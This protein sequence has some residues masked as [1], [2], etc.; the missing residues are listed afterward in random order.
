MSLDLTELLDPELREPLRQMLSQMPAMNFDDLPAA[1]ANSQK[2]MEEMRKHIPVIPGIITEDRM[3]PG[4]ENAPDVMIRIYRPENLTGVLPGF[5]WIHGGGYIMGDVESIDMMAR[6]LT[7][8]AECVTVSVE[9]RLAPEH[10]HPAPVEDC[11]AALKWFFANAGEL[12]V[13]ASRIAV[14]GGSAGGGLAAGLALLAR[15]RGEVDIV[16]Q[17]LI[18]PMIDDR[19]TEPAGET[20]RDALFWTRSHNL[21]GWR[22]YLG[23]EP[24]G[25]NV[26]CYAAASRAVNLE[27]LPP[28]YICVGGLD[29]FA[30]EDIIY[31]GRLTNAGVPIELH[32][33]P[34]GPHAFDGMVPNADVSK[35]FTADIH[36]A[37]KRALHG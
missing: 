31:A 26:S 14:G 23:F 17:L 5:L 28:T 36:H 13:D 16:Y 8:A 27:G 18:Y 25:E 24:G 10:P 30:V 35:R 1:R 21:L 2:Q 3:I 19:T 7:L 20:V 6:Q 37:L 12:N 11:Y 22:S 9:Y 33:Y 29:L 15:D 32:V 34:G 4:P